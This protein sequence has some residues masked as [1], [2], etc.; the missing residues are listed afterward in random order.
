[1]KSKANNPFF[2]GVWEELQ[3]DMQ[4]VLSAC[5]DADDEESRHRLVWFANSA[6]SRLDA[7]VAL[8]SHE[9]KEK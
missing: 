1:M 2:R 6:K 7:L 8:V 3:Y 9:E 4:K 5:H